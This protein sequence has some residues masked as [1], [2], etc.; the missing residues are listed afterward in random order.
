MPSLDLEEAF[1]PTSYPY[2]LTAAGMR[3]TWRSAAVAS[4]RRGLW[5]DAVE[6]YANAWRR[7]PPDQWKSGIRILGN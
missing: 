6:A 2:G 1:T 7:F 4:V 3:R 5:R